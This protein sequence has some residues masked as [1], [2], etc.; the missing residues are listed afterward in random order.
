MSD[1]LQLD[2]TMQAFKQSPCYAELQSIV[3]TY[4]TVGDAKIVQ[5]KDRIWDSCVR[6]GMGYEKV[7]HVKEC[8]AC[9][10]NRGG[11]GLSWYRAH[12]RASKI[13]ISGFSLP[14][15]VDN[16]FG[17][18]DH[19]I[20]R[21][22]AKYTAQLSN[23][24]PHYARYD[25]MQVKIGCLGASHATHGF[26]CVYDEVPCDI[27]SLSTNGTIDKT[28]VY[29]NDEALRNACEHGLPFK[30]IR[31]QVATE[32]PVVLKIVQRA[33]NTVMQIG[34]GESW[35]QNLLSIVDT[36]NNRVS[37]SGGHVNWT[38]VKKSVI[39]SQPPRMEDIPQMADY[40]QCWGGMPS[41]M[42][43]QDLSDMC[44]QFM[45]SNR[46]VSGTFFK[47]LTDL[48]SA[49]GIVA[50]PAHLIN[51]LL[52]VHAVTDQDT[53][54]F[55]RYITK[56][57]VMSLG[58]PKNAAIVAEADGI[59]KRSRQLS[60]DQSHISYIKRMT[61][62]LELLKSIVDKVTGKSK[63]KD[64]LTLQEIASRF[65]ATIVSPDATPSSLI[66]HESIIVGTNVVQY[67]TDGESVGNCM[68][69]FINR[70]YTIGMT[71]M[72]TKPTVGKHPSI[73]TVTSVDE[74]GIVHM[75]DESVFGEKL[76][77]LAV[78]MEAFPKMFKKC[79]ALSAIDVIMQSKAGSS[80]EYRNLHF[81]SMFALA[82]NVLVKKIPIPLVHMIL[83]PVRGVF[84]QRP[85]AVGEYNVAPVTVNMQLERS[86]RPCPVG[87]V[88]ATID[89]QDA[90][91]S[92]PRLWLM[93]Q[94]PS[95][96]FAS[97]FWVAQISHDKSQSNC[98][99][100]MTPVRSKTPTANAN[101][102]QATSIVMVP[103]IRNFVS[104]PDRGEIIVFKEKNVEPVKIAATPATTIKSVTDVGS[105]QAVTGA[106]KRIKIA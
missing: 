102:A 22:F 94:Q 38:K 55:A 33:L 56:S 44:K 5:I 13:K 8:G 28:V 36:A 95:K 66:A 61:A 97:Q 39:L 41:G 74:Q 71:V 46:I 105:K 106:A 11:E 10:T 85:F 24:D 99:V 100:V 26:A 73:A 93:P 75:D 104:I 4:E 67:S 12:S 80:I 42:F 70:G 101:F 20:D 63:T 16:A 48:K 3:E 86:G 50:L 27:E 51:A 92:P 35:V 81:K 18:E 30:I 78:S 52:V 68:A 103:S 54:G 62:M 69:S 31:W 47:Y 65:V 57:D 34:E 25:E 64:A 21:I 76:P 90:G 96:D 43:I 77:K 15:I 37:H 45:P 29:K 87:A 82:V 91:E 98:T 84:A 23:T 79:E 14:A 72:N 49:F 17:M 19:P 40:I 53:D 88:Q 1:Y 6:G 58:L 7:M 59:I 83:K 60:N 89:C 32:F 9:P 2:Q